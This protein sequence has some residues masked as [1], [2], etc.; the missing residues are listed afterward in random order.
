LDTKS[1]GA[2]RFDSAFL[3]G[4]AASFGF[5]AGELAGF[6]SPALEAGTATGVFNPVFRSQNGGDRFTASLAFMDAQGK[7]SET[8]AIFGGVSADASS[9]G[10]SVRFTGTVIGE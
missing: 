1:R 3:A 9:R 5:G 8:A 4:T 6:K 2:G 10:G 7:A